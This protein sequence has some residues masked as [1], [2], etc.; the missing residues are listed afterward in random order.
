[1]IPLSPP[2]DYGGGGTGFWPNERV[3]DAEHTT[4]QPEIVLKPRQGSVLLYGGGT[5]HAGMPV[6]SG[7]RVIFLASFSLRRID[8]QLMESD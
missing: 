4:G 7:C 3:D 6:E 5:T 1:M 2:D 8:M